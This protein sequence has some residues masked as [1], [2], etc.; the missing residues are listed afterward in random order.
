MENTTPVKQEYRPAPSEFPGCQSGPKLTSI[1]VP[2]PTSLPSL[3]SAM[4]RLSLSL[5]ELT[6]SHAK[7]AASM[8]SLADERQTL[9]VK[10]KEMRSMVEKSEQ[11]R[12]WFHAFREWVETIATF[13]DEKVCYIL[14]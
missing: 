13:L 2:P 12:S 8:S 11:K 14:A 5:T 7:N 3:E 9:D 4:S 6:E 10:E 1:P